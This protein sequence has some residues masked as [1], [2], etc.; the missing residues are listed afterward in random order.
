MFLIALLLISCSI[1]RAG[2]TQDAPDGNDGSGGEGDGTGDDGSD[3]SDLEVSGDE[4]FDEIDL[5]SFPCPDEPRIFILQVNSTLFAK[6]E[7]GAYYTQHNDENT[8]SSAAQLL[9]SK[10]GVVQPYPEFDSVFVI[11]EGKSGDC[12]ISGKGEFSIKVSGTCKGS[13]ASLNVVGEWKSW[14]QTI[15]CP[16][17]API[18]ASEGAFPAPSIEG[19]FWLTESGHTIGEPL[20]FPDLKIDYSW[21]LIPEQESPIPMD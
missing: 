4:A 6:D 3:S 16:G 12:D 14:S 1:Q 20:E 13:V 9:I 15:Q 2:S 11:I 8:G 17:K 7:D 19:D 18:T 21:K 5:T 10:D